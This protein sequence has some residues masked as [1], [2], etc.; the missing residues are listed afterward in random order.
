VSTTLELLPNGSQR[1][2]FPA[3]RVQLVVI[4]QNWL[5]S[6]QLRK[7]EDAGGRLSDLCAQ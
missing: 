3:Q 2:H 1:L 5:E 6:R 7:A 4:S